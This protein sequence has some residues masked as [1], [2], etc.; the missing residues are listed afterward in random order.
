[1]RRLLMHGV[2]AAFLAVPSIAAA[3]DPDVSG[4]VVQARRDIQAAVDIGSADE[5]LGVRATLLALSD[6]EQA[7]T[8]VQYT[9]AYLDWR[10]VPLWLREHEGDKETALRYVEEGLAA[11]RAVQKAEP[12]NAE[13]FAL[14]SS[15]LGL[16][17]MGAGADVMTL[18][19]LSMQA[20]MKAAKL[21]PA[22]P[23]VLFLQGLS[24][25]YT[26]AQFG[27]GAA[28]A[29]AVLRDAAR[30]AAA[31]APA[32]SLA[33][34][35]GHDDAA[36]W[37]AQACMQSGQGADA[38]AALRDALAANPRNGMALALQRQWAAAPADSA[39]GN[40]PAKAGK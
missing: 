21:A 26:P 11:A 20:M 35:W 9:L 1:M 14:E 34:A 36:V 18:G 27:G 16:K 38:R 6:A 2:F 22:N 33:P 4:A 24:L 31:D 32:D 40:T 28:P 39:S 17:M 7:S 25:L 23:R 37:L 30:A 15:L 13:A 3:V 12:K 29:I 8:P 19:P 5:L 10:V